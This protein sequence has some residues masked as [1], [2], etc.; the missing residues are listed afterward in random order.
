M[1]AMRVGAMKNLEALMA[2]LGLSIRRLDDDARVRAARREG[3][4]ELDDPGFV[5]DV[6]GVEL[7]GED[8]G[9]VVDLV[10]LDRAG[11]VGDV[12]E[13]GGVLG[14]SSVCCAK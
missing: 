12:V 2:V 1:R 9:A 5:D 14:M 4:D 8:G 7:D 3:V 11:V 6:V 10:G 13:P